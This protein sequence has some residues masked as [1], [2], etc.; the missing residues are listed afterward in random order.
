MKRPMERMELAPVSPV[1]PRAHTEQ[2]LEEGAGAI[3]PSNRGDWKP[4]NR[5]GLGS[6]GGGGRERSFLVETVST[7]CRARAQ[8][9]EG[10]LRGS[11]S[12]ECAKSELS[13]KIGRFCLE[14]LQ[15]L[16]TCHPN[17]ALKGQL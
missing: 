11:R 7:N 1:N 5:G 4:S 17:G 6:A 15:C 12:S 2:W 10:A 8:S 16:R 14:S 9:A 13:R 3:K